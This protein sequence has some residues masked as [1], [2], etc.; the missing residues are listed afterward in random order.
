M[1]EQGTDSLASLKPSFTCK[2][3]MV[4]SEMGWRGLGGAPGGGHPEDTGCLFSHLW[5]SDSVPQGCARD[6]IFFF[7]NFY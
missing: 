3:G 2:A 7:S 5:E 6:F 4:T 1:W